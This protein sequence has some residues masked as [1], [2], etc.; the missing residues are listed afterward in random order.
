MPFISPQQA[1]L[2][3]AIWAERWLRNLISFAIEYRT[4]HTK[5]LPISV[6][7]FKTGLALATGFCHGLYHT[8]VRGWQEAS[9]PSPLFAFALLLPDCRTPQAT[10]LMPIQDDHRDE[11]SGDHDARRHTDS[12]IDEFYRDSNRKRS[13]LHAHLLSQNRAKFYSLSEL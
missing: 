4:D 8:G 5:K 6:R 9:P 10:D 12:S 11:E 3:T 7:D 13:Q 2:L 1:S